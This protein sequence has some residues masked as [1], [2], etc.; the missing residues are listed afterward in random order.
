M[1]AKNVAKR[2]IDAKAQDQLVRFRL[3]VVE[4]GVRRPQLLDANGIRPADDRNPARHGVQEFARTEKVRVGTGLPQRAAARPQHRRH[5]LISNVAE[6]H[7]RGWK[8]RS[9][10]A[11]EGDQ[12]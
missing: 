4:T 3:I 10:A 12:R 7:T 11:G 8:R 1:F 5:T 2:V 6:V 9:D